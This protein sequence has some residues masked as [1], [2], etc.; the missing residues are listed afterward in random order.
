MIV[1]TGA[2]GFLGAHIL[3]MLIANGEHVRAIR[4]NSSDLDFV[5][6]VFHNFGN[7]HDFE[8]IEWFDADILDYFSLE[9]A[10]QNAHTVIHAAAM[11]SFANKDKAK[12]YQ[13]NVNGTENVVNACLFQ[14][15]KDLIFISSIAALGR[16]DLSEPITESTPWKNSPDN[17]WYALS[18]NAAEREVWRGAEEGLNVIVLNPGVIIGYA[19]WNHSSG[20]IFKSI[21]K[22]IPFYTSGANGF[23]DVRDV[24]NILIKLKD[25]EIRNEKFILVSETLSFKNMMEIVAQELHV[26]AP[27]SSI[28]PNVLKPI[29]KI[30]NWFSN[31]TGK[32]PV[33][34][35]DLARTAFKWSEYKNDKIKNTLQFEFKPVAKSLKETAQWFKKEAI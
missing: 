5:K 17:S 26:K 34:S 31:L 30:T 11:V 15:V 1:V 22:G 12:M 2:S 35:P 6:R 18:K 24:V 7:A 23:V 28:S 19:D 25:S 8:K 10:F 16:S 21:N 9:N 14:N 4:R 32:D 33:L 27:K 20:K 3:Q 13:I 29:I